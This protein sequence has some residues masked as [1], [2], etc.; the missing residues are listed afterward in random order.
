MRKGTPLDV[1]YKGTYIESIHR[2]I[3]EFKNE[4]YCVVYQCQLYK[5]DQD[6]LGRLIIDMHDPLKF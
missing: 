3:H 1:L 4:P 5:L 2:E 6:C